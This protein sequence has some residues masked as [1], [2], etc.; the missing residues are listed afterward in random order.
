M[1]VEKMKNIFRKE[2]PLKELMPDSGIHEF[3]I[4]NE[5][6]IGVSYEHDE[7]GK[8]IYYFNIFIG[9]EYIDF[10]NG[11]TFD[12]IYDAVETVTEEWN[13]W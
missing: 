5:K 13:K 9:E 7:N 1:T 6:S 2:I 3:H 8:L 10:T 4:E 11:S 12:S